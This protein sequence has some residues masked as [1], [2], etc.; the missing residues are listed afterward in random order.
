MLNRRAQRIAAE[1]KAAYDR[2][3]KK[4]HDQVKAMDARAK[5]EREQ[6]R[7]EVERRARANS[8]LS[9]GVPLD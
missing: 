9:T 8:W 4:I 1:E 6:M 2:R 5:K 7:K 3:M